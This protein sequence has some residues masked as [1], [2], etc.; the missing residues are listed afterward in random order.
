MPARK[1]G[2]NRR[3]G[4]HP[5]S[6][7]LA[8]VVGLSVT[9]CDGLLDVE[10]PGETEAAAMDNP[11]F[12]EL[13]VL[14]VQADFEC[15]YSGF[16]LL[17]ALLT[18]EMTGASTAL[19]MQWFQQRGVR[20][21]IND[22]ISC[23]LAGYYR[24]LSTARFV[25]DDALRRIGAFPDAQVPNKNLLLA[26]S[27]LYSAFSY[28]IF[29]E[30]YCSATFDLGPETFRPEILALAEGRF[31][32]AIQLASQVG[33]ADIL[34][35]ARVGRAR[36]RLQRGNEAG[37]LSDA[38]AVPVGFRFDV[39]RSN[40]DVSRRNR[41]YTQN[42][43][44]TN[45]TIDWRY[46]ETTWMGVP[47]PRIRVVDTNRVAT[48]GLHPAWHQTKYTSESSPIRLAS[49]VEAQLIIAEIEGG[50]T[51][52][53]VI[54]ML[55]EAAGIPGFESTDEAEIRAQVIEERRREFFLEGRRM[56]DLNWFGGWEDWADGVNPWDNR[57]YE[58]TRCFPIPNE[59]RQG[60]PN[61]S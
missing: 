59:E 38:S 44:V 12:A 19:P 46:W 49:Y 60:N 43:L 61:L 25:A 23:N 52:V 56:G 34:N 3:R 10:M 29:G 18:G 1:D 39:T 30:A 57:P 40:S 45:H 35:A 27:A 55:H 24:A 37:A 26:R 7:T 53:N 21:V 32:T 58:G 11:M 41:I 51:A 47:D 48:D 22:N 50:Q 31:D 4:H 28:T 15:F 54:N 42:T 36:V 14:G 2:Y 17:A 16:T 9:A 33:N 5:L 8:V 20:P 6:W 13:L